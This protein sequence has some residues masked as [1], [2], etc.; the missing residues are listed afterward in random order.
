VVPDLGHRL[1]QARLTCTH[2]AQTRTLTR[3]KV[4]LTRAAEPSAAPDRPS[5]NRDVLGIRLIATAIAGG[6]R[7]GQAGDRGGHADAVVL[8]DSWGPQDRS[9][10]PGPCRRRPSARRG[11]ADGP[12]RPTRPDRRA[13]AP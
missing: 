13:R 6:L 1:P 10:G 12:A 2:G 7:A 9:P 11:D 8:F 3:P 5:G 4:N